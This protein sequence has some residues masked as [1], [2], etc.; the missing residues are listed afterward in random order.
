MS[1]VYRETFRVRASEIGPGGAMRLPALLD[2]FQEVAGTSATQLGWSSDRL[3]AEG[4]TWVLVRHHLRLRELPVWREEIAVETWPSGAHRVLALR[5][6]RAMGADGRVLAEATSGWLLVGVPS[7]KPLRLPPEIDAIA[8]DSP[9]RVIEDL[10]DPLPPPHADAAPAAASF[11]V[12]RFDLD[13]NAHANNVAI[14]R[15]LLETL[16][17]LDPPFGLEVEFKGEVFEGDFLEGRMDGDE[18]AR[19]VAL[20]RAADGREV[21][22]ATL[23]PARSDSEKTS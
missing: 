20:R 15:A 5:E 3:L 8:Q 22:R 7:K 9:G 14:F 11:R 12:G 21:A 10:F 6:F 2:L 19:R 18:F 23:R 13:L 1:P 4:R 16:P 17:P